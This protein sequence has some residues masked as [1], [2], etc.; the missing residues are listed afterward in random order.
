MRRYL[1]FRVLVTVTILINLIPLLTGCSSRI[2]KENVATLVFSK[3]PANNDLRVPINAKITLLF[4]ALLDPSTLSSDLFILLDSSGQAVPLKMDYSPFPS[5]GTSILTL[6][7][8]SY[9]Q[10]PPV[11]LNINSEYTM[12]VGGGIKDLAGNA[13]TL[14]NVWSFSTNNSTDTTPPIFGGVI[15]AEGL[16]M[17]S[18]RLTWGPAVDNSGGTPSN[19][20]IFGICISLSPTPC[21]KNF[22]PLFINPSATIDSNGNYNFIVKSLKP[23]TRYYFMVRVIDMAGNQDANIVQVTAITKG[24]KLYASNFLSNEILGFQASN[25]SSSTVRSIRASQNGLTDPYGMYYDQ[26]KNRLYISTCQ[27]T[28]D[29]SLIESKVQPSCVSGSSKIAIYDNT[30]TLPGKDQVPDRTIIGSGLDGPVG[31]FLDNSGGNDTLYVANYIG[32]SVTIYKQVNNACNAVLLSNNTCMITPSSNF[33]SNDLSTPFGIALDTTNRLLYVSNYI[34]CFL[35]PDSLGKT[36]PVISGSTIAVFDDTLLLGARRYSA[37]KTIG[38]TNALSFPAGLWF[39][40]SSDTLYIANPGAILGP[41]GEKIYPGIVAICNVSR[42]PTGSQPLPGADTCTP[43][44]AGTRI[45]A[46]PNTGFLLPVQMAI[47]YST[48]TTPSS[49][50][51]LYVS[52]YS[53]NDV[54][55]FSPNPLFSASGAYYNTPPFYNAP[56]GHILYGPNNQIRK[57]IGIAVS[58]DI[59]GNDNLYLANSGLDQIFFFDQIV[60]SYSQ[61]QGSGPS[62]CT[63]API[64]AISPLISMPTGLF[65]NNSVDASGNLQDRL[66][67]SNF[68]NNTIVVIDGAST[69]TGNIFDAP[70]PIYKVISS[71]DIH[72]PFGIYVDTS[73]LKELIYVVNSRADASGMFSVV[74]F[75]MA[76]CTLIVNEC[77]NPPD[78]VIY[79]TD[80]N[81]PAGIWVD[82]QRDKLIVSNRGQT[83]YSSPGSIVLFSN[84]STLS[85]SISATTII[86]G[87]QTFLLGPS[88][89]LFDSSSDQLYVSNQERNDVLVFNQ[90]QNCTVTLGLNICNIAPDRIIYNS[91]DLSHPLNYPNS[92]ALDLSGNRLFVSNLGLNNNSPSLLTFNGA[93]SANGNAAVGSYLSNLSLNANLGIQLNLPESIALDV[94]R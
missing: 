21:T 58:D 63:F 56:P 29:L 31:I 78:R 83:S 67:I 2:G 9:S 73:S 35:C 25:L 85:G 37:N 68:L 61:C 70:N 92:L 62:L 66:Y 77:K 24:G 64:R 42:I 16:D 38:G 91:T 90:P 44:T 45:L 71:P 75:D 84:S 79:S 30:M 19:K 52:D 4:N 88:G 48:G 23:D 40:S 20:L 72:N 82:T 54:I 13:M 14:L 22:V 32:K 86:Q 74:V 11:Y 89:L 7:P 80:F 12:T 57:P 33:V 15:S 46:G 5:S 87:D 28:K 18:I 1:C 81:Y 76:D 8:V 60:Q 36:Q 47:S 49:T 51:S 27:P 59:S 93:S 39:D 65:L 50:P 10:S 3:S 41:T 17:G 6:T 43:T 34:E 53:N 55:V 94:T 26:V 69:L